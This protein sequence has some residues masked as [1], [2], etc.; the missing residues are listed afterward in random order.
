MFE[1]LK[2]MRGFMQYKKLQKIETV[3]I[4][5]REPVGIKIP[6]SIP[7]LAALARKD[8]DLD[9]AELSPLRNFPCANQIS[10][11]N[12]SSIILK[13]RLGHSDKSAYFV[14]ANT[15]YSVSNLDYNSFDI[16]NTDASTATTDT[17]V[18]VHVIYEHTPRVNVIAGAM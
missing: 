16:T 18:V 10:I 12:T 13:V 9:D 17:Q 6:I 15:I 5:Y 7:L 14:P 11:I 2:G 8:Y 4:S 1:G 3:P